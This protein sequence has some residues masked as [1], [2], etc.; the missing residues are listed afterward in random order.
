[1]V[2]P[3]DQHVNG[4][5]KELLRTDFKIIKGESAHQKRMR[6]MS[7]CKT[8]CSQSLSLRSIK[9]G[10]KKS[11]LFPLDPQMVLNTGM[12]VEKPR[13]EGEESI[14]RRPK[15]GKK[16]DG[17]I[18]TINDLYYELNEELEL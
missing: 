12:V 13:T 8:V 5:F 17:G 2:Q 1:M 14:P 4:Y 6:L 16:F 15:R 10:W 18:V 3:L 7:C 9:I 11:G